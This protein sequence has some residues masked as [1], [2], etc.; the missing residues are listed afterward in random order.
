M[1]PV[2][3]IDFDGTLCHDRFWRSAEPE[4]LVRIQNA[5]F[6]TDTERVNAWMLGR[7]SSEEI[8]QWL[9]RELNIEYEKLWKLFVNDCERMFVEPR[10][11]EH[12]QELRKQYLIILVTDNMDC[13]DRFTVPSLGLNRYFYQIV[14]SSREGVSKNEQEGIL[15][16]KLFE[17]LGVSPEETRLFDN[18]R[19]TCLL[20]EKFGGSGSLVT[21][22][23]PL[24][25]L[26]E[27]IP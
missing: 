5:L 25:R 15:F 21:T 9:A 1:K 3:F 17:A 18:S 27:Q 10:V 7:Y 11:L 20:F 6:G 23:E 12:I 26:L 2:L 24:L 19:N 14:N 16:R 22:E 4:L 8:H 13:F